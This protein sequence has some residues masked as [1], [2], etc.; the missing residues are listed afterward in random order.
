MDREI[1]D[2]VARASADPAVVGIIITGA[3]RRCAGADMKL[4]SNISSG[5]ESSNDAGSA[6]AEG[7]AAA[8][9]S[10]DFDG[11]FRFL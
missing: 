9:S 6:V 5:D 10:G 7:E 4:L 1:R 8:D 11:R 2:A 3:G